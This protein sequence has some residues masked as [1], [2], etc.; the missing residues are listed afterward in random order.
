MLQAQV[1]SQELYAAFDNFAHKWTEAEAAHAAVHAEA[2]EM[3]RTLRAA[4]Q[5][6]DV[7]ISELR[8]QIAA[9]KQTFREAQDRPPSPSQAEF[10]KVSL[11]LAES[12]RLLDECA[13][14]ISELEQAFGQSMQTREHLAT[15]LGTAKSQAAEAIQARSST[16]AELARV[17]A[18][19]VEA[20][21][22]I[23]FWR[24][25]Y[26]KVDEFA[27]CARKELVTLRE[28][29]AVARSQATDGVSLVR[30]T[31]EG[32]IAR[33]E[34]DL[35]R[36]VAQNVL[37]REKDTLITDDVRRRAAECEEALASAEG[38]RAQA[39]AAHREAERLQVVIDSME[40]GSFHGSDSGSD[41]D[42]ERTP[43]PEPHTSYR[44]GN[45]DDLIWRCLVRSSTGATCNAIHTT[46]VVS[47]FFCSRLGTY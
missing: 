39:E 23:I 20:E 26:A 4:S 1:P 6:K 16:N 17:Q 2:Q 15:E 5:T 45:P 21:N 25:R 42:E 10:A 46:R 22:T 31:L 30:G 24:G 12:Q 11:E 28:E 14:R 3:I 29:A 37:L 33:L 9:N 32:R 7:Q 43:V 35:R 36:A 47:T 41:S 38:W 8:A 44:D 13:V 27:D 19:L 40:D 34:E 18:R